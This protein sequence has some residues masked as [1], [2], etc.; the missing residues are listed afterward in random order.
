MK[1][2]KSDNI[3]CWQ[4]KKQQKHSSTADGMQIGVVTLEGTV[5]VSYKDKH[6]LSI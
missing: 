1:I 3:K 5:A 6:T 4:D 2:K